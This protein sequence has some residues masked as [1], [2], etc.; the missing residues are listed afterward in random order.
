MVPISMSIHNWKTENAAFERKA[1]EAE[2][3]DEVSGAVRLDASAG[4][5]LSWRILEECPVPYA[6]SLD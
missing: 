1:A 3:K 5:A 2:L 6:S 4:M